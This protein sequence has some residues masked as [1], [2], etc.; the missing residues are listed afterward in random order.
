MFKSTIDR[1]APAPDQRHTPYLGGAKEFSGDVT[2]KRLVWGDD[3]KEIELLAVWFSA[4]ART[5]PHT[6]SVDQ[7]LLIMEGT[8]AFGDER[9]VTLA[10]AGQVLTIPAGTWHWHGAT[11]Y[12]PMMHIS[13]RKL[14]NSTDWEVAEKNWVKQYQELLRSLN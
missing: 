4:G 13:V 1:S 14:P 11:P 12:S 9:G 3:S 8:C 10:D 6:H 2:L 7:V 5:R